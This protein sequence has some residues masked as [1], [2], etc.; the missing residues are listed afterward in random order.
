MEEINKQQPV[1]QENKIEGIVK[2]LLEG[3]ASPEQVIV[4][5][6]ELATSGEITPEELEQGKAI[7]S[8][9]VQE[10]QDKDDAQKMF[11]LDFIG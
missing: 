1:A 3:G 7:V 11:G 2:Q 6:E 4:G 8:G 9:L 5:L 10:K